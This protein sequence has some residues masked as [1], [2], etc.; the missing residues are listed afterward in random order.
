MAKRNAALPEDER[1]EFRIG[2][3][4]C[5]VVVEGD[6]IYGDG[7]CVVAGLLTTVGPGGICVSGTAF[8]QV[9]AK[10]DVGFEILWERK[11]KNFLEPLRAYRVLI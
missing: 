3:N 9:E 4:L 2:I 7:I 5:E 11:P 8:D 10:L 1:L 6:D